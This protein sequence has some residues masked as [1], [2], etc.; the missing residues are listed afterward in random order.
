VRLV[1]VGPA[2]GTLE[3]TN[4]GTT[5]LTAR[6]AGVVGT[7]TVRV[8][9]RSV[10]VGSVTLHLADP[11]ADSLEVGQ[12]SALA[13][14]IRD[15]AG[16]SLFLGNNGAAG[17]VTALWFVSDT[18]VL[19][20]VGTG[21]G[22]PWLEAHAPGRVTVVGRVNGVEG[23]LSLLV[24]PTPANALPTPV[25]GSH[26]W[27]AV[28]AGNEHTCGLTADGIVHCWGRNFYHQLGVP[29]AP[30][31]GVPRPVPLPVAATRLSVGFE[32]SCA[33]GRD[34]AVYCWGRGD[35]GRLGTYDDPPSNG[36]PGAIPGTGVVR[37]AVATPFA[38][39]S[40]GST[41]SCALTTAGEA[42][43]W[44]FDEYGALGLR[45]PDQTYACW[46]GGLPYYCR[47][48]AAPVTTTLR[49]TS[50]AAGTNHT[51]ALTADGAAWCWGATNLGRGDE[52]FLATCLF[53]G[54]TGGGPTV[55]RSA[56]CNPVPTPVL[57]GARFTTLATGLAGG[58]TCGVRTDGALLCWSERLLPTPVAGL[59][60]VRTVGIGV[61]HSCAVTTADAVLCWGTNASGQL[62]VAG[63]ASSATPIAVE[64]PASPAR[65]TSAGATHSCAVTRDG[66]AACWGNP[67]SGRL[68]YGS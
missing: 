30:A 29:G 45:A 7:W 23:T 10:P 17:R 64:Q 63:V 6:A 14:D 60:S 44:G 57:G 51:C 35:L 68:G 65:S 25:A 46:F 42:Y 50:I 59:A 56:P 49:F 4:V 26:T 19:R 34:G 9:P 36:P 61:A 13:A 66:R 18:T 31:A 62:G 20:L 53:F 21:F 39:V 37:V 22:A 8:V 38:E 28:G 47:L 52:P 41:H 55:P 43:C 2:G 67:R 54:R 3:A 16:R 12:Q 1:D 5:T 40:A 33:V 32:H 24:V 27:V 58:P 48:T 15:T 11:G